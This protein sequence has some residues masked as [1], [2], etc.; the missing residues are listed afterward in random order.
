MYQSHKSPFP[1]CN[2]GCS[3]ED[4]ATD[5]LLKWMLQQSTPEASRMH[6]YL[7]VARASMV[8]DV[9]GIKTSAQFINNLLDNIQQQ[10]AMN[11]LI[12][13]S[14]ALETSK[15]VLDVLWHLMIGSWQSKPHNQKQNS[16]TLRN[17]NGVKSNA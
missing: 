13:D 17:R 14:D 12:S 7:L 1:A 8:V 15:C 4:V 2:V 10:G 11:R 16:R 5:T 6:R 9:Y 3:N